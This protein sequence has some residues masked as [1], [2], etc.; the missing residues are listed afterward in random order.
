MPIFPPYPLGI[1][2]L[3]GT[4]H[5]LMC[6]QGRHPEGC[7]DSSV[8]K[9]TLC[10]LSLACDPVPSLSF[11]CS[12]SS[13]SSASWLIYFSSSLLLA[14]FI[15][16][17]HPSFCPLSPR[18]SQRELF[19]LYQLFAPRTQNSVN[20]M[21]TLMSFQFPG[22]RKACHSPSIPLVCLLSVLRDFLGGNCYRLR[23]S[24]ISFLV[25]GMFL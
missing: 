24:P 3:G 16:S 7:G 5:L 15:L 19:Y 22:L 18:L 9:S 21:T 6:C 2:L 11:S 12:H 13:S 17:A 4:E 1:W 10:L 25:T 14:L 8:G 20:R 23:C